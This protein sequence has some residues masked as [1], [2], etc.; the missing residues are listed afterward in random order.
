VMGRDDRL[1]SVY[2]NLVHRLSD[3]DPAAWRNQ[4]PLRRHHHSMQHVEISRWKSFARPA[5]KIF[6]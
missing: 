5:I 2:L 4:V 3:I 1:L 6:H